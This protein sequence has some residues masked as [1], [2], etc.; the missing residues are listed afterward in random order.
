MTTSLFIIALIAAILF[1]VTLVRKPQIIPAAV[2]DMRSQ[3]ILF[4]VRLPPALLA[5]AF[6]SLIVPTDLVVPYIGAESGWQGILI[7]TVF[8]AMI[9]GGPIL[10]FPM[11]LVLW[12][13]GVGEAQMVALLASWSIFAVHRLISYEIPL[14]GGRFV[15]IRLASAWVLPL[16]AGF[17]ALAIVSIAA[18]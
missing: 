16:V 18:P 13:A 6:L 7:A 3:I 5:A 4:G 2:G 1:T 9:P 12:R 10:T 15:L 8:G 14:L 17:L 11:A